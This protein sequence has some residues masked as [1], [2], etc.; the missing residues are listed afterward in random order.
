M[1]GLLNC[2][3]ATGPVAGLLKDVA[4]IT[5]CRVGLLICSVASIDVVVSLLNR[6]YAAT[7][8]G[9]V[10]FQNC[11]VMDCCADWPPGCPSELCFGLCFFELHC[12]CE[13]FVFGL[14][15]V[16]V[17]FCVIRLLS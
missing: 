6:F 7:A 17:L 12:L 2:F 3:A 8:F 15:G 16:S 4:S 10:G 13:H 1:G 11:S 9:T 14:L 5:A